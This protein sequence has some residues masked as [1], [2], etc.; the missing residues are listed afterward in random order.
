[1]AAMAQANS[2]V[3]FFAFDPHVANGFATNVNGVLVPLRTQVTLSQYE[4]ALVNEVRSVSGASGLSYYIVRLPG[5][6]AVR[7]SYRLSLRVKGR[8]LLVVA[9]QY[10]FLHA[11]RSVV[12]TYTTLPASARFYSGVFATSARS[13]RFS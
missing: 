7:L 1:L 11:G 8:R 12:I 10:G 3:K 5:G 6:K 2:P 13:I 9:L 4:Q